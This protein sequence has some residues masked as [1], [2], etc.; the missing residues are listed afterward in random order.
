M[1]PIARNEK[2]L[3]AAL[4][5]F[6]KATGRTQGD[7]AGDT[8]KRQATVSTLEAGAGTLE[9]LFSVLSALEL[10]LVIRPRGRSKT[11]ADLADLF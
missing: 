1:E 5:R 9:S 7:L 6:R 3:G 10:E 2:Q 11:P 8:G 4:R